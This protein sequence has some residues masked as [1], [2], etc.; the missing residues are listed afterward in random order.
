MEISVR[1]N[2]LVASMKNELNLKVVSII[3]ITECFRYPV[4]KGYWA[5]G[6]DKQ[7]TENLSVPS[8][9][10][11]LCASVSF[12]FFFAASFLCLSRPQNRQQ[13]PPAPRFADSHSIYSQKWAFC[14]Y[15]KSEFQKRASDW[16]LP[17]PIYHT[18]VAESHRINM[19]AVQVKEISQDSVG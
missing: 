12:L 7:D 1:Y 18:Q 9:L 3:T 17:G 5:S 4:Q 8:V 15:H 14:H 11:S 10:A 2:T 6:E 13:P 16:F 19:A